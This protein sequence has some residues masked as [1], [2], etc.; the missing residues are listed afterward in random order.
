MLRHFVWTFLFFSTVVCAQQSATTQ[1]VATP[2]PQQR[3]FFPKDTIWAWAQ[4]DL[5]PPHNEI[6]PNLCRGNTAQ[7]GGANAPCN[8]FARYEASG[9]IEAWPFGRGVFRRFFLYWDPKFFFGKNVPQANYTYSFD[10]IG[11]ENE[12]GGGIA[13]P[14]GFEVRLRQH[15]LFTRFG[16]RSQNLGPADLGTDGPYGRFFS[17]AARKY[18]GK[19]RFE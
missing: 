2:E 18:F 6:D 13:L 11:L 8:L 14:K 15:F 9:Y 5:A 4:F 3:M 1:S 19:R 10:P 12:W 17:I 7:Y 16:D